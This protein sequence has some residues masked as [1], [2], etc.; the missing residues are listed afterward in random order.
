MTKPPSPAPILWTFAGLVV[1]VAAIYVINPFHARSAEIH[2][3]VLGIGFYRQASLSMEPAMHRGQLFI[4]N[5]AELRARD[6]RA[7]E[8][9]AFRFPMDPGVKYIKRVVATGGSTVE[10]RAGALYV[11]GKRVDEPYLANP[12]PVRD[13]NDTFGPIDVPPGH[14]FVLG[15][16]RGNSMDSRM[17]GTVPSEDV[18]GVYNP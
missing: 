14:F 3:R 4:V 12:L 6:P 8:I 16:N 17:W 10:M 9:I 15:D 2:E 5:V 13:Q 11:D 18:I 7:G 1:L